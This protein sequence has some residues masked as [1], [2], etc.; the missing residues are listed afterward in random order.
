MWPQC[1]P[2]R[3]LRRCFAGKALIDRGSV[4]VAVD[5]LPLAVLA[6][7]DVGDAQVYGSTGTPST[8]TA[9]C[10]KPTV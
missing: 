3:L 5:D 1:G 6:T 10:S 9:V 8:D 2:E 4:A 7:V